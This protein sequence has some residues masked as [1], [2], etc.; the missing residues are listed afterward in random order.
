[1]LPDEFVTRMTGLLGQAEAEVFFAALSEP[2][3]VALRHNRLKPAPLP[4]GWKGQPVPW[5]PAAVRLLERP[6]FTLEPAFHAGG[7]YVQEAASMAIAQWLP[8]SSGPLR[9][10]DLCAA[11]GGKAT[12]LIDAA[13]AG[14]VVV[15]NEA[16]RGRAG[17][18]VETAIRWGHSHLI[19]TQNDPRDFAALAGAFDVVLVDAPC[20]GEGLW[21]RRPQGIKDFSQGQIEHCAARQA[22]ILEDALPLVR[23]GG[24]LIYSTCTWAEEENEERISALTKANAGRFAPLPAPQLKDWGWVETD[25]GGFPAYRAYP[26]RVAGEGLFVAALQVLD[27]PEAEPPRARKPARDK[28]PAPPPELAVFHDKG[29]CLKTTGDVWRWQPETARQWLEEWGALLRIEKAGVTLGT[30]KGRDFV[31]DHE[32]ALSGDAPQFFPAMEIDRETALRYLKKEA[33]DV[34]EAKGFFSVRHSGLALGWIKSL[35][36]RSNNLLPKSWRILRDLDAL[37][38]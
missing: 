17:Q 37:E 23:A 10:L 12:L 27:G 2:P 14:S 38:A 1:M 30:V 7:W 28:Q 29:G 34:S 32:W 11:P 36:N 6:V 20:S 22:R 15:A 3:S 21:R 33:I 19:V 24:R 5:L 18:L 4:D 26:H 8:V 9:I 16:I 35:G 13:P 25:E 31:P